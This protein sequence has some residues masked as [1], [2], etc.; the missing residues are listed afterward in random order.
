MK[1]SGNHLANDGNKKFLDRRP[2][3]AAMRGNIQDT[4]NTKCRKRKLK[5]S[6]GNVARMYYELW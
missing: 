3:G 1:Y 6:W 2:H 4:G 5:I